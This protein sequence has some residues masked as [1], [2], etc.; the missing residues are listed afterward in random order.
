MRG[1]W[2]PQPQTDEKPPLPGTVEKLPEKADN[3]PRPD[4]EG[5]EAEICVGV[6]SSESVGE[7]FG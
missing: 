1:R 3:V 7:H 5:I 4:P 2:P 6:F